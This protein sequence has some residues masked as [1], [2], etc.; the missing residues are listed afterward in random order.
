MSATVVR[1]VTPK[2]LLFI[3]VLAF[4][5]MFVFVPGAAAGNF[6]EEKMGCA[7]EN[8]AICKTGTVGE[9]YSLEIYLVPPDGGRGE[10]FGCARFVHGEPWPPGLTISDEGFIHGTPTQ[11]GEYQFYMTVHYD[12]N[13]GCFK[14]PSDDQFVIKINPGVPVLPKLTIGPES[15]SPGTVG[16]S[17]QLQM[18]ANLADAKTWSIG[19]GA[20]PPGLLIDASTGLI[21][22]TPL[23]AGEYTFTVLARIDDQRSDTK[24]LTI[25]VRNPL[26]IGGNGTFAADTH[27]AQTE[28]GV[29]FSGRLLVTGGHGP[30]EVEQ[31]GLLP[32]GVEFDVS[33]NSLSGQPEVAGSYRF[34]LTAEDSEGR[35]A[36]Y[37]ATI[38]V[39]P[40]LAIAT[41]RVKDG[42]VGSRYRAKLLSRGGVSPLE[43]RV[44]AG[45]LPR[46][47]RFDRTT[48]TF[49]GVPVKAGIWVITMELRDALRVKSTAT[50]M[51][52]V[53]PLLA[54]RGKR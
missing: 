27:L 34:T 33:D 48:A 37:A 49:V 10:D 3:V 31:T 15:T 29:R 39:S 12:K 19:G 6:D 53:K 23:T 51:L 11:A 26:A 44:K 21:S 42:R 30:Y 16:S 25:A 1:R 20:L 43:W 46:G 14:V 35:T 36:T 22:G 4:S 24:T 7:G 47:I 9:P 5:A 28:V 45:P 40:R 38:V 52:V 32:D 50:V 8:P 18:T 13:P 2:R 54:R 41:K 17:Y